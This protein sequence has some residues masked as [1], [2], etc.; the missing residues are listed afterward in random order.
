MCWALRLQFKKMFLGH[1]PDTLV[2]SKKHAV[3]LRCHGPKAGVQ[4]FGNHYFPR[5]PYKLGNGLRETQVR[6]LDRGG[7]AVGHKRAEVL[8][9]TGLGGL[10]LLGPLDLFDLLGSLVVLLLLDLFSAAKLYSG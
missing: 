10:V 5:R 8:G 3:F 1:G 9:L 6:L 2:T 4:E 7:T